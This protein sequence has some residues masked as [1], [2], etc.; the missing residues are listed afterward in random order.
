MTD[1]PEYLEARERLAKD[2]ADDE[3]AYPGRSFML[4]YRNDLRTLLAGPPVSRED[5]ARAWMER[6][7][8]EGCPVIREDLL[9]ADR[10]IALYRGEAK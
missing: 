8:G 9:N 4:I 6:Q 3:R 5:V 1:L 7:L 2:L 10:V